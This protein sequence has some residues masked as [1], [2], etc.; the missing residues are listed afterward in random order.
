MT[1]F[2]ITILLIAAVLVIAVFT[3]FRLSDEQ[4]D[5]LKWIVTRW[6]YFVVFIA[7]IVKTFEV[8]YGLETVTIVGG[9][10]AMLAGLLHISNQTYEENKKIL[11]YQDTDE[12]QMLMM[13]SM[14]EENE[15]QMIKGE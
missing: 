2:I 4:Y 3:R 8:P 14:L 10:G 9:I 15:Q 6:D 12:N 11:E 5:R 1:F 7:L 13:E